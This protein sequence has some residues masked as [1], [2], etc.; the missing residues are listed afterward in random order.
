[1]R[2]L[3]SAYRAYTS[4]EVLYLEHG[5]PYRRKLRDPHRTDRD[6]KI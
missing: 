5:E 2:R 1:M 4:R 6:L 3:A